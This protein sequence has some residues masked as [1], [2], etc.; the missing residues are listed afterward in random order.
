MPSVI[1]REKFLLVAVLA[2][3][4]SFFAEHSILAAGQ[5]AALLAAVLLIGVIVLTS[6]RALPITQRFSP[7]R[8]EIPTAP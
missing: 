6:T 8:W 1:K 2:A 4:L 7:T 3:A 5:L